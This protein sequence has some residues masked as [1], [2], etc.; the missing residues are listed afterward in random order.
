MMKYKKILI[1]F[2]LAASGM[3]SEINGEPVVKGDIVIFT[4]YTG[5]F[6]YDEILKSSEGTLL[7]TCNESGRLI[8]VEYNYK[9]AA[10][11]KSEGSDNY[12]LYRNAALSLK[13]G[14]YAVIS[15][16]NENG[17][18]VL[19]LEV[20]P[21]SGKFANLKC[22]KIVR[23]HI[24]ENIP[25]KAARELALL[26]NGIELKGEVMDVFD[27]GAALINSGQWHGLETGNYPTGDGE[28]KIT[29]V[30]RYSA[31]VRGI[32]FTKGQ[33]LDF[34][35][36][37]RLDGYIKKVNAGIKENAVK[38]YGTDEVLNK[39]DGSVRESIKGTCVINQGANV[40][41][42]GY[43]SYLSL[44]YMGIENGKADY[45]G[46]FITA[47][48]TAV[49][50]GLVPVLT[51]F[52]VKFLP[53]MEDS[54]RTAG[55]KRL[56]YFLWGTI[57]FT[58]T[59]S[60]YSQLAYN[61]TGKSMLPPMFADS[62]VSAAVLSLLLPGG[63]MFY[64]GYR[65]TGWGIYAGEMSILGYAVYTGDKS[66]RNLLLGSLAAIKGI[67]IAASYFISPSYTFFNREISSAGDVDF[68]IGLN[69]AG[70]M[71]GELNASVT[72]RY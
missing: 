53:W 10:I 60:F 30:S 42:P 64:K 44:G 62:D 59:A 49:H 33:V 50:V 29:D 14:L 13:T 24:P 40:C 9:K 39:K 63:G 36:A 41:L 68:S 56:N 1:I 54:D 27:D 48:L 38:F 45:A 3:F 5:S 6:I 46:V 35:T 34:K 12:S 32:K 8:P 57:P 28:I 18:Y 31:V 58:F 67:E 22:E 7:E 23:S 25:L 69:G 47:S 55:M 20:F 61:Y 26:L 4:S 72:L 65:W 37:S 17:E 15:S 70:D 2:A 11:E 19:K 21:L 51:D 43:G 71:K 52:D 66:R 16:Y